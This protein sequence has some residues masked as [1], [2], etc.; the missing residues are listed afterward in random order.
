MT[1]LSRTDIVTSNKAGITISAMLNVS[2][3]EIQV[4]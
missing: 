4:K 1:L 3:L 2:L